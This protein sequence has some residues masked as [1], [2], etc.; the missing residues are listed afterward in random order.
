VKRRT[1]FNAKRKKA[2]NPLRVDPTRTASL[3]RKFIREVKSKFARLRYDIFRL[4]VE[5]DALGLHPRPNPFALNFAMP[6]NCGGPGSGIPG[7]CPSGVA[8]PDEVGGEGRSSILDKLKAAGAK[9]GAVE[10]FLKEKFVQQFEKL[11]SPVQTVLTAVYHTAFAGWTASQALAE[12]TSIERGSTPEQAAKLRGVLSAA[13]LALFKP[14]SIG[15]TASGVGAGVQSATW[16][17]PPATGAY[18]AYSTARNPMATYRAAKG[19]VKEGVGK[20]AGGLKGFLSKRTQPVGN[21]KDSALSDDDARTIAEA[22]ER[23]G[24]ND[25]YIAILTA[26]LEELA[27]APK[28]KAVELA[29]LIFKENPTDKSTPSA[30]DAAVLFPAKNVVGNARWNFHSNPDKIKAF[31]QW[32]KAQMD[33]TIRSRTEEQLWA[34]YV[35][36]GFKKGAGRAFDDTKKAQRIIDE[37][38]EGLDFYRGTKEEFLRSSFARPVAVEKVKLLAGRSFDELEGVTSQMA[39]RMTRALAD[40]LVQGKSPRDI[41]R[42]LDNDLDIGRERALTIA[43]T[44]IIRAHAEGQLEALSQL[45]VEEVGVAVEW[46]TTGDDKVCE[47]CEPLEGVVLKLEE[48]RGLLPRHPNCRCAWI[49]ANVGEDDDNQ[50]DTKSSIADSLDESVEREGGNDRSA[51]TGADASISPNRPEPIVGNDLKEF[52]RFIV[53]GG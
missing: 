8:A 3:R 30:D 45:G 20:L 25:W 10:H 37:N 32:L 44:E 42:D 17:V 50:K 24:Y 31:K 7:P 27:E 51:W 46:S 14:L 49:P 18:L 5:E 22:L 12:R 21:A 48:A 1:V 38:K 29:D 23:Q 15:L 2:P 26:V 53:G 43:R 47:L 33:A 16:I 36:E 6:M 34:A 40:G 35:E 39:Q 4:I 13:D 41:A 11:P 9:A 52:S 28:E 19:L